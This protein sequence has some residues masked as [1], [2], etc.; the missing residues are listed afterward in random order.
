MVPRGRSDAARE[1]CLDVPGSRDARRSPPPGRVPLSGDRPARWTRRHLDLLAETSTTT[2]PVIDPAALPRILPGYDLW[3]LWP[4]QEEDGA[5]AR[6]RRPRLWMALSAPAL[7]HPEHA[8][9]RRGSV[10]SQERRRVEGPGERLRRR[11]LTRQPRMVRIGGPPVRRHRVRVLHGRRAAR[12][13]TPDVPAERHRDP[14]RPGRRRRS[15]HAATGCRASRAPA[16]RRPDVSTGR[17]GRR[18]TGP[19]QGVPRS[20]LVPRPG[21]RARLSPGRRIHR[22]GGRLHG[23][24][25]LAEPGASAWSLL[26]PLLVA[27]GVN[28]ELERPHVIVHDSGT[29]SSSTNATPST[30]PIARPPGSTASPRPA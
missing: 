22:G 5:S 25:A 19:Y 20:R 18:G 13:S 23:A 1:R 29:T 27:E 28:H 21:R 16:L 2:A 3:D 7:G 8:T 17:R 14:P 26:P 11:R 12:R 9:T 6:G 24:I 30:R 4:I 15:D 10:C